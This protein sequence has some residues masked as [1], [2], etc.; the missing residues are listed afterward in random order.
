MAFVVALES[1]VTAYTVDYIVD[2]IMDAVALF[3]KIFP[4]YGNKPLYG[5]IASVK[6][7]PAVIR[8]A[9]QAGFYLAELN[10][11]TSRFKRLLLPPIAKDYNRAQ[12]GV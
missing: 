4:S 12:L 10:A 9:H 3:P 1:T 5:L 8:K 2:Y 7:S 6:F 11:D